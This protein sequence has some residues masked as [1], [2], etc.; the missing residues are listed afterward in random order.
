MMMMMMATDDDKDDDEKSLPLFSFCC[1][2]YC[3]VCTRRRRQ[4]ES[5][6][7]VVEK[8]VVA[9]FRQTVSAASGVRLPVP[10]YTNSVALVTRPSSPKAVFT[11][12]TLFGAQRQD[13]FK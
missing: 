12:A 10:W 8:E 6:G 5:R 2:R 11:P 7:R 1:A 3:S 13:N 9:G 4:K